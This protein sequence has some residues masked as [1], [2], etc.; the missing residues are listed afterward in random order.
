M[1]YILTN[2]YTSSWLDDPGQDFVSVLLPL[3]VE[4]NEDTAVGE[5]PVYESF[6]SYQVYD[7]TGRLLLNTNNAAELSNLKGIF[8]VKAA[9]KEGA[10]KTYKIVL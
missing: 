2:N 3:T 5:I 8:I 4:E 9:N 10:S 6:D 1:K 7:L